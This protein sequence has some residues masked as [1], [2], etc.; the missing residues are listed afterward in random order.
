MHADEPGHA[1]HEPAHRPLGEPVD[2]LLRRDQVDHRVGVEAGRQRQLDEDPVHVGVGR[3]LG[4]GRLDLA[5]RDVGRQ[6]DVRGRSLPVSVA[7]R[8]LLR[9]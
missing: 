5:L 4:D 2:V 3:Q 8:C 7:L 6:V 9:T 1:A